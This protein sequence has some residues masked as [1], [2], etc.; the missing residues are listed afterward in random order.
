MGM[1]CLY[2]PFDPK[3]SLRLRPREISRVYDYDH[4]NDDD[5]DDDDDDDD[6]MRICVPSAPKH[7]RACWAN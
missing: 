2:I 1:Y 6:D 7:P 3:I 5:V 4:D